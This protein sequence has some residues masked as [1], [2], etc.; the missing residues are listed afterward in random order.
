MTGYTAALEESGYN[1]KKWLKEHIIR[2]MGVCASLRDEGDLS[3]KEIAKRVTRHTDTLY[4]TKALKDSKRNLAGFKKRSEKQW[5]K[6][7]TEASKQAKKEYNEAMKRF[8]K[9]KAGLEASLAEVTAYQIEATR[10]NLGVVIINTLGFAIEQLVTTIKYEC[11][12]SRGSV[13]QNTVKTWAENQ[14]EA[15]KLSIKY[16]EESLRKARSRAS[17]QATGYSDFVKFVD[18][19]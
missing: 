1:V 12:P 14:I 19:V 18:T 16:N 2:G 7:Y 3:E 15:A 17:E 9:R 8:S 6:A 11:P 5:L 13:L 10:K 4:Y